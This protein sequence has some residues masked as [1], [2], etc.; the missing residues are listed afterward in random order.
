MVSEEI[1]NFLFSFPFM[2]FDDLMLLDQR[3]VCSIVG[4]DKPSISRTTRTRSIE[5]LRALIIFSG[6]DLV[7]KYLLYTGYLM[8]QHFQGPLWP[9][10]PLLDFEGN[11]L[12]PLS[13]FLDYLLGKGRVQKWGSPLD[14]NREFPAPQCSLR[15][16]H[17]S[18][19]RWRS[20]SHMRPTSMT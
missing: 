5:R 12:M 9:W 17:V 4:M 6:P 15:P 18:L 2:M 3:C 20:R 1:W 16:W 14:S 8:S 10:A 11:T 13:W 7:F 19:P